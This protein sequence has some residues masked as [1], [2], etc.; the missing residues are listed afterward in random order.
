MAATVHNRFLL[1]ISLE[2]IDNLDFCKLVNHL[3]IFIDLDKVMSVNV[4]QAS[5]LAIS[6]SVSLGKCLVLVQNDNICTV[7][8][9]SAWNIALEW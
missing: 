4:M 3:H 5:Y 9:K 2:M 8:E 7:L 6:F 1:Q